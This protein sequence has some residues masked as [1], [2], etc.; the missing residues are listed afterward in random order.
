MDS[1]PKPVMDISLNDID[2]YQPFV[3]TN[4]PKESYKTFDDYF[5]VL[6]NKMMNMFYGVA[7]NG[8]FNVWDIYVLYSSGIQY[9]I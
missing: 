1:H 9:V 8:V 2:Q 3:E 5:D 7:L 4:T 6:S